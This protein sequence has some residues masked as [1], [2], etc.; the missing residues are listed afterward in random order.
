MIDHPSSLLRSSSAFTLVTPLCLTA[1]T[2]VMAILPTCPGLTVDILVKD[3]PLQEY[4]DDESES[5][6]PNTV[7]RYIKAQSD[8]EFSIRYLSSRHLPRP[9]FSVRIYIDGE[10]NGGCVYAK[11][12]NEF[13]LN[14]HYIRLGRHGQSESGTVLQKFQFS[15]ITTGKHS[16]LTY[17]G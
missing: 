16:P 7:L 10:Y 14:H 5:E 17:V 9:E 3:V 6:L 8:V 12:V 4:H 15:E 2:F 13:E 11:N 1:L